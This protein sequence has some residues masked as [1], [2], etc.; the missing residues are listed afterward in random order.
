MVIRTYGA[1]GVRGCADRL[2]PRVPGD[3]GERQ[4]GFSDAESYRLTGRCFGVDNSCFLDILH[5][6]RT[7]QKNAPGGE[8]DT[9]RGAGLHAGEGGAEVRP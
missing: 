4:S 1:G 3:S 2:P 6:G 9:D 7:L 8:R 5:I